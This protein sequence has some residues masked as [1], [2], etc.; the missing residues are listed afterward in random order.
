MSGLRDLVTGAGCSAGDGSGASNNPAARFA[1]AL[2]GGASKAGNGQLRD[3]PGASSCCDAVS[4]SEWAQRRLTACCL[5]PGLSAQ[6]VDA[7]VREFQ[8]SAFA[9]DGAAFQSPGASWAR[10]WGARGQDTAAT[11]TVPVL[12]A[13]WGAGPPGMQAPGLQFLQQFQGG[14]S[15]E[16]AP[17]A[18]PLASGAPPQQALAG[19]LQSFVASSRSGVP[20]M[21]MAMPEL[22]LS[23]ADKQRIR[24]RSGILAR[25]MF[26][27]GGE[28]FVE[29]QV[30][31][32]LQSLRIDEAVRPP[33][34]VAQ[35][36]GG[37][38]AQ[39][40][41]DFV[42]AGPSGPGAFQEH[43]RAQAMRAREW[44][45]SFA[46]A[47]QPPGQEASPTWGVDEFLGGQAQAAEQGHAA[48]D[49]AMQG[50]HAQQTR[51]LVDALSAS[52]EPKFQN[53][54][55]LQFVSKMSRGELIF[56][57][58]AVKERSPGAA[59]GEEFVSTAGAGPA[60]AA[61]GD[62]FH[63]RQHDIRAQ[64]SSVPD[65]WASEF[66][67]VPAQWAHEFDQLHK[68]G[69][70]AE[71]GGEDWAEA[72]ASFME[73]HGI[74]GADGD[75]AALWDE[76]AAARGEYTF[77]PDNPYT[78]H[79]DPLAEGIDLFRRG[80]LSE[81]V[82]ALE[83]AAARSPGTAE[84]WRLLG[85]VHAENDDDRRAIAAMSRALAAQPD[86]GEVLLSLGVSHTNELDAETAMGYVSSWLAQHPT[87]GHLARSVPPGAP[88]E[89]L[90]GAFRQA[91]EATPQD[92]DIHSV[93]GVLYTLTRDYDAAISS[94]SAALALR[95]GDYSLWNKLGATQA[96]SNRSG[97]AI[98][99]YQRA[100]DLKPN[101]VRAWCNMGIGYANQGQY[102]KSAAY[103]VRAL[104]LNPRADNMW[105]YLRISLASC[106]R[107]DLMPALDAHDIGPLQEAF[108]L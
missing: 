5:C 91:A 89:A 27:D 39:W 2:L 99:C 12:S 7:H 41:N 55:F 3:L 65:A 84:P 68:E 16:V 22:G 81:A 47:V 32:L 37:M 44:A 28:R 45:D 87:H 38:G 71:A 75:M 31:A 10:R 19:Y 69:R 6:S 85:T 86:N 63:A 70:G 74:N 83:A 9:Q 100:L 46:Q 66:Q 67:S 78:T 53:S 103:Y 26:S 60:G 40:A 93:L 58:N 101:Y 35:V 17:L 18:E 94:F 51:A 80:V 13:A 88:L 77:T 90:L 73:E 59:W 1:D 8:A 105:G 79:P 42:G 76:A 92:A 102:A 52:S 48:G 25:H 43:D 54:K 95:P 64:H 11:D 34:G 21:P 57:G 33:G 104:S 49:G 20:L 62:E 72:Y 14:A 15:P 30:G 50:A 97:D 61:W 108:P 106:G 82:L 56:D 36:Q 98:A 24:D 23:P 107:E 29:H 96:N 4:P